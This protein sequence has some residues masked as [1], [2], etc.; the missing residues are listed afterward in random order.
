M[1]NKLTLLFLLFSVV[2]CSQKNN[3]SVYPHHLT[4]KEIYQ[5]NF[6]M[7][8]SLFLNLEEN[9]A[10]KI[11]FLDNEFD[12]LPV[13]W[14][15]IKLKINYLFGKARKIIKK[16]NFLLTQS[17]VD[18][19]EISFQTSILANILM[20]KAFRDVSDFYDENEI[21]FRVG[22]SFFTLRELVEII[23]SKPLPKFFPGFATSDMIM[24]QRTPSCVGYVGALF[25]RVLN[26]F[27]RKES[28]KPDYNNLALQLYK[29]SREHYFFAPVDG[30]SKLE[31]LLEDFKEN[32]I[33]EDYLKIDF[34]NCNNLRAGLLLG[35]AVLISS[36][37]DRD[38]K[39]SLNFNSETN[40][41]HAFLATSFGANSIV[42]ANS[43][44]N[45]WGKNGFGE[46]YDDKVQKLSKIFICVIKI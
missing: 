22:K 40:T 10:R 45:E 1:L 13:D 38:L 5:Q 42:F 18:I 20:Q 39:T 23:S 2:A 32:G 24:T 3:L 16:G 6:E 12:H 9:T 27:L 14:K 35:Q 33:I 43:W 36:G 8:K 7:M 31:F 11:V 17:N 28:K 37:K 4:D 34:V 19:Q 25:L 46:I 29:K 21:N 15:E 30:G 26:K 44:G 41:S